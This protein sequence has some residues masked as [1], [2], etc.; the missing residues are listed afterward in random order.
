MSK[1]Q[2][3]GIKLKFTQNR[4][5]FKYFDYC[6]LL[7]QCLRIHVNTFYQNLY[8]CNRISCDVLFVIYLSRIEFKL[9]IIT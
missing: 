7:M 8:N 6:V 3:V 5:S 2:I 4:S 9:I 1:N